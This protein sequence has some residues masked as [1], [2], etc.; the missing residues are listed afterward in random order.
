MNDAGHR[1][2]DWASVRARLQASE[3]S[4]L[5]NAAANS[6][7]AEKLFRRRARMMAR[8]GLDAGP[9]GELL[10]VL[11]FRLAGERFAVE[12][13]E[14]KE[15]LRLSRVTPVPGAPSALLGLIHLRGEIR[16]VVHLARLLDLPVDE[17][18][19]PTHVLVVHRRDI[20]VGLAV[21]ETETVRTVSAR[22]AVPPAG[23]SSTLATRYLKGMLPETLP[24]LSIDAVLS[25]TV[26]KEANDS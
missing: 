6:L 3:L 16:P 20:E 24:L 22:D 18:A 19:P 17:T 7:S 10:D 12:L 15:V 23:E 11:T 2:I 5:E 21:L 9:S 13:S 26:F 1:P 25:H 8:R 14:L 4:S